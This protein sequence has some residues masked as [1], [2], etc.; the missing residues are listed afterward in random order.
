MDQ[1]TGP[2]DQQHLI[3]TLLLLKEKNQGEFWSVFCWISINK[4]WYILYCGSSKLVFVP[5]ENLIQTILDRWNPKTERMLLSSY[6]CCVFLHSSKRWL[7]VK[8]RVWNREVNSVHFESTKETVTCV[9]VIWLLWFQERKS[10][11]DTLNCCC[12]LFLLPL[13][14]TFWFFS[15]NKQSV[16]QMGWSNILLRYSTKSHARMTS[17]SKSIYSSAIKAEVKRHESLQSAINRLSKQFERVVDQQLRSG[18]KVYLHSIQGE[19]SFSEPTLL[20]LV[21][22]RTYY[23]QCAIPMKY[24]K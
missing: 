22:V 1:V 12:L 18:L 14:L 15:W 11:R 16:V 3:E 2:F 17:T 8:S 7:V 13:C 6:H 20:T 9:V 10:E 23:C 21:F 19:S 4:D 24:L 5:F